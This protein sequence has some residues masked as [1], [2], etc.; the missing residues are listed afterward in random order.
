MTTVFTRLYETEKAAE[1]VKARLHFERLPRNA[2]RLFKAGVHDRDTL[3]DKLTREGVPESA[4]GR[5][6][7]AM[8]AGNTLLVAKATYKPLTATTITRNALAEY[9]ALDAGVAP[10]ESY[11]PDR[12]SKTPGVMTDHPLFF[13][14]PYVPGHSKHVPISTAWG[15]PLLAQKR[16][17]S[18]VI[19]GGRTM[20]KAFWPTPL[21]SQKRRKKLSV[22]SGGRYM[23]RGFWPMPLL[24]RRPRGVS[25]IPG[26]SL[27]FSRLFGLPVISRR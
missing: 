23:S 1:K 5:Y 19:R 24:S 27:P 17:K 14:T 7:D 6:A 20:S 4:A 22:M 26:G 2:V 11:M 3:V 25:V 13:T 15:L 8:Q 16:K 21:L 18:S 10:E 12:A 9:A